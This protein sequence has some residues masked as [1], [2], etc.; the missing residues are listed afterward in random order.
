MEV[1][2]G[3]HE[4]FPGRPGWIVKVVAEHGTEFLQALIPTQN[5]HEYTV[6][7]VDRV[8]WTSWVGKIGLEPYSIF[9]GD[10]PEKYCELKE[11]EEQGVWET[12]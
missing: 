9:F 5:Q 7:T 12:V 8:P 6:V 4:I 1:L 3:F 2:G 10:H 11:R